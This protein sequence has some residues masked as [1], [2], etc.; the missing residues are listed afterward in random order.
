MGE[1]AERLL[2]ILHSLA[3]GRPHQGLVPR[4]PTVR[5]GLVPHLAPQGMVRQAF[6]LVRASPRSHLGHLTSDKCL[7]GLNDAG[8]ERPPPLLE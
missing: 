6:D 8:M 3:V 4:L 5:Q 7:E 1:G 2:E